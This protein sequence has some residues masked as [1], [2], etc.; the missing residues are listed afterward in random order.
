MRCVAGVCSFAHPLFIWEKY[1]HEFLAEVYEERFPERAEVLI[2]KVEDAE[3][4]DSAKQL[5]AQMLEQLIVDSPTDNVALNRLADQRANAVVKYIT[6][7]DGGLKER[8]FL[9]NHEVKASAEE[10]E[11]FIDLKLGAGD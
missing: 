1:Y 3:D 11:I 7:Q 8:M 9:L 6:D 4:T 10:G 5:Y 2:D